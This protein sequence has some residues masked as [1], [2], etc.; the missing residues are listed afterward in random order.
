MATALPSLV[1]IS[2]IHEARVRAVEYKA[3]QAPWRSVILQLVQM[4][5]Q[6]EGD[7]SRASEFPA[8]T[9]VPVSDDYRKKDKVLFSSGAEPQ[10][11]LRHVLYLLSNERASGRRAPITRLPSISSTEEFDKPHS[12]CTAKAKTELKGY[13]SG[14]GESLYTICSCADSRGDV[15]KMAG[16]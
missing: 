14:C 4:N 9:D 1:S 5:S 13:R 7:S 11:A 16:R 15:Y 6:C 3:A 10:M 2:R 8:R 12:V